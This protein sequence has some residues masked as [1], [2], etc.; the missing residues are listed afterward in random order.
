MDFTSTGKTSLPIEPA[1]GSKCRLD[2]QYA[3][4]DWVKRS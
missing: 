1:T 2:D 4:V 3:L